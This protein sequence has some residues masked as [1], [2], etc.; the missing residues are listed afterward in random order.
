MTKVDRVNGVCGLDLAVTVDLLMDPSLE[1][2][3]EGENEGA[4]VSDLLPPPLARSS[5]TAAK[6]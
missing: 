1:A 2:A 6:R 3:K 4:L 5:C